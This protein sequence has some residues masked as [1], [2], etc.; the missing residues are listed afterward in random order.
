MNRAASFFPCPAPARGKNRLLPSARTLLE[1]VGKA[2]AVPPCRIGL[3]RFDAAFTLLEVMI[4][5]GVLGI[6]LLALLSLHN[7]DMRSVIRAREL[8]EAAMLA[9]GLMTEAELQG[10]PPLGKTSGNFWKI[11]PG[12]YLSFRW[13]RMVEES[14]IA[15]NVRQV[16]VTIQYGAG[17]RNNFTV[18]EFV[19]YPEPQTA[20]PAA[21]NQAPLGLQ[22]RPLGQQ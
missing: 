14:P 11:H 4:A 8:S 2:A 15:P 20:P 6:A 5:V 1:K 3:S 21:G 19:Y 17:F 7:Q 9:Q 18:V 10:F 13:Q 16:E 12:Q 22:G